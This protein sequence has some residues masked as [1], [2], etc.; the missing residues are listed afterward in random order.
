MLKD[1]VRVQQCFAGIPSGLLPIAVQQALEVSITQLLP[2]IAYLLQL[3]QLCIAMTLSWQTDVGPDTAPSLTQT[4]DVKSDFLDNYEL[5]V[6]ERLQGP[7][8]ECHSNSRSSSQIRSSDQKWELKP[9]FTQGTQLSSLALEQLT[10]QPDQFR[11]DER[12]GISD[13]KLLGPL[14]TILSPISTRLADL[15]RPANSQPTLPDQSWSAQPQG[16]QNSPSIA[17]DSRISAADLVPALITKQ[18]KTADRQAAEAKRSDLKPG[19][20]TAAAAV[21]AE[22]LQR[23]QATINFDPKGSISHL[24]AAYD[25]VAPS[26]KGAFLAADTTLPSMDHTDLRGLLSYYQ[27]LAQTKFLQ[28][29]CRAVLR[30]FQGFSAI[31]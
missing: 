10:N 29:S 13:D 15:E 23:L 21:D 26:K 27:Q 28:E 22:H 5:P 11:A 2:C 19:P 6:V 18:V 4:L 17:A 24:V 7:E 30:S 3:Y 9:F 12:S 14:D 31:S 25:Q 20:A 16:W 1:I 8:A